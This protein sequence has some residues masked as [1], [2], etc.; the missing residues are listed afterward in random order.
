MKVYCQTPKA[1][2][3]RIYTGIPRTQKRSPCNAATSGGIFEGISPKV[4]TS[5]QV[6]ASSARNPPGG[7]QNC[8]SA[9][10]WTGARGSFSLTPFIRPKIVEKN[11]LNFEGIETRSILSRLHRSVQSVR[12][13]PSPLVSM[14]TLFCVVVVSLTDTLVYRVGIRYRS[15]IS[16]GIGRCVTKRYTPTHSRGDSRPQY[17]RMI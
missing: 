12:L 15:P 4:G 5:S 11:T 7:S 8:D 10:S 9:I 17:S 14:L 2:F 3:P 16:G 6:G 13:T 1:C